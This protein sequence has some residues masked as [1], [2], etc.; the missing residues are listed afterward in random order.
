MRT[1]R[2]AWLGIPAGAPWAGAAASPLGAETKAELALLQEAWPSTGSQLLSPL[3]QSRGCY[4]DRACCLT[5]LGVGRV[6]FKAF[7]VCYFVYL[8]CDNAGQVLC[9]F[10][11]W[12]DWGSARW[13]ESQSRQALVQGQGGG[14]VW[15]PARRYQRLGPPSHWQLPQLHGQEWLLLPRPQLSGAPG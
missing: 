1:Q 6:L 4:E 13:M 7:G 8:D 10:Y 3:A 9:P 15:P 2:A 5:A 14:R 11:R 12:R